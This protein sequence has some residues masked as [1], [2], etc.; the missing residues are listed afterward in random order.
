MKTGEK[1]KHFRRMKSLTQEELANILGV[2]VMTI[3]RFEAGK[4]EPKTSMITKIADALSVS[5]SDLLDS[6]IYSKV[7]RAMKIMV[8]ELPQTRLID[9]FERLIKTGK[10]TAVQRVQE[11]TE[12]ERYTK[13][14][15]PQE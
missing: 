9:A 5:A 4:V 8:D 12:I 1:I 11:L 2:S 13:P 10:E 7:D 3:R 6:E 15:E 14:E